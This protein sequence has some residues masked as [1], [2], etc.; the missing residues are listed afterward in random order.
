ML[1]GLKDGTCTVVYWTAPPQVRIQ[2]QSVI[3]RDANGNEVRAKYPSM[4][5]VAREI[6]SLED[7]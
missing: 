1:K 7:C 2:D 4:F 3:A 6:S 5:S